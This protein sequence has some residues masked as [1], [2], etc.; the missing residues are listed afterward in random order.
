VNCGEADASASDPVV[1]STG[2]RESD[3]DELALHVDQSSP[4]LP[5]MIEALVCG[6]P[7]KVS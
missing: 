6:I 5:G 2:P 1:G 4:L 3:A 7:L